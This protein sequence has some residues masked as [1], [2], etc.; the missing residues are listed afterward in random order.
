MQETYDK[1][2]QNKE[3]EGIDAEEEEEEKTRAIRST[4]DAGILVNS[5]LHDI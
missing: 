2:N 5:V 1:K 4:Y 3:Y